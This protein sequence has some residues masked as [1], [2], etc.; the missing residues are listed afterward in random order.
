MSQGGFMILKLKFTAVALFMLG[1]FAFSSC[2]GG[3]GGDSGDSEGD[4]GSA[5]VTF[6]SAD[7]PGDV[8]AI[9]V[10]THTVKMNYANNQESIKFTF[11]P[12]GGSPANNKYATLTKKFFISETEVTNA[13]F[14]EVLQWALNNGK[15]VEIPGEHNEV[16]IT[17]VKY[18]TQALIA[19]DSTYVKISYNGDTD[20]FSVASGYENHPAVAVSWYGAIMFCNWLTEMRD[21]N[22]DNVVYTDIPTN[23]T[24]NSGNTYNS[25]DDSKTGYRLPSSE[26]WEYAARYIGTNAPTAGDL[27]TQYIARLYNSGSYYLTAGYYWTPATYASGATADFNDSTATA[28]VAVYLENS[29]SSVAAVRSKASNTL[30]LYDMSGNVWEWCFNTM[31]TTTRVVRGASWDN[32]ANYLRVGYWGGYGPANMYG[33]LGFRFA[34]TH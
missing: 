6:D 20:T 28:L 2:G 33:F 31:S 3:G 32:T 5:T 24:W 34:R 11:S 4:G 13:V 26:E 22:T 9:T 8:V 29:G 19:L 23:G 7:T 1:V 14:A 30:G 18:G 10:G 27:A 12:T 15:I 25:L 21:G 16:N 17:R